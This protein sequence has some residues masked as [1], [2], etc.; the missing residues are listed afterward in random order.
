LRNMRYSD[1]KIN[2]YRHKINSAYRQINNAIQRDF[3]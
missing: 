3:Y 2:G 1:R